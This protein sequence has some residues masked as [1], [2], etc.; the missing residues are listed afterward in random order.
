[1]SAVQTAALFAAEGFI[2]GFEDDPNQVGISELL[3]QVRCAQTEP[4]TI[5]FTEWRCG[6]HGQRPED[7]PVESP[8]QASLILDAISHAITQP[9]HARAVLMSATHAIQAYITDDSVHVGYGGAVTF[10]EQFTYDDTRPII[11]CGTPEQ[12]AEMETPELNEAFEAIYG[13][14]VDRWDGKSEVGDTEVLCTTLLSHEVQA[15]AAPVEWHE[16]NRHQP[17]NLPP[18]IELAVDVLVKL[19]DEA[20]VIAQQHAEAE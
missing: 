20:A 10:P 17:F 6:H 19:R 13:G 9:G 14:M 11:I 2:L 3:E 7:I 4:L 12:L 15:I 16:E 5:R 8:A 1:M 18:V